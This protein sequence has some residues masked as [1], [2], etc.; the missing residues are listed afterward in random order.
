MLSQNFKK[1]ESG[2]YFPVINGIEF[3]L[4]IKT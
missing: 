1:H 4:P 2:N 3:N